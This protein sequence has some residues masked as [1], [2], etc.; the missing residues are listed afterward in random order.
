MPLTTLLG[1][2][3][4]PQEHQCDNNVCISKQWVC[5]GEPDC[6]DGSDEAGCEATRMP[7]PSKRSTVINPVTSKSEIPE[8]QENPDPDVTTEFQT[9]IPITLTTQRKSIKEGI[10][11]SELQMNCVLKCSSK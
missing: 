10:L 11:P 2:K 8:V 9:E 4:G 6:L 3:C 1:L 5:D 7:K